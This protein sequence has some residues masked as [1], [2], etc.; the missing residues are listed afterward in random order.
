MGEVLAVLSGKGGTGKT[1]LCAAI[2][3]SLGSAGATV[4]CVDCDIG[5]RN[6]DLALGMEQPP[7]ISF[8]DAMANGSAYGAG[9]HPDFPEVHLLTAPV[10][11]TAED[12]DSE[13]FGR[14]IRELLNQHAYILLDAPAGVGRGFHLAASLASRCILVAGADPGSLRDA[15]RT[16]QILELMEKPWV[17]LAVNRVNP[18]LYAQMGC[19]V[20]DMMDTVGLPLLGLVPEDR[21]VPLAAAFGKPLILYTK[22]G[23]ARACRNMALR[24]MGQWVPLM[25][26]N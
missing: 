13:G 7:A 1:S 8:V 20:D 12:V 18:G 11:M 17:R 26:I 14:M 24:I 15:A 6:L 21:S 9:I 23:A 10:G 2:A 25:K 3:T 16:A 4:L 5:L 19:N 22:R